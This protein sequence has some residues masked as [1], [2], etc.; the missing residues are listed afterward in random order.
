MARRLHYSITDILDIVSNNIVEVADTPELHDVVR[1]EYVD[2]T[3]RWT[4]K[5]SAA[6][7]HSTFSTP[8]TVSMA[9]DSI[10]GILVISFEQ[11]DKCGGSNP[12]PRPTGKVTSHNR[13]VK[14]SS[15]LFRQCSKTI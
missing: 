1:K 12:A 2:V 7:S 14:T 8:A 4:D 13:M 5:M 15:D 3:A 11:G 6:N 9:F 10:A